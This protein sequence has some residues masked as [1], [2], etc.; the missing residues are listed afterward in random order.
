MAYINHDIDDAVRMGLINIE[1]LTVQ[2]SDL[3]GKTQN[4]KM[5]FLVTNVIS[6]T[7]S[8]KYGKVSMKNRFI[9]A[10]EIMR[11]FLFQNV[12]ESDM[13]CK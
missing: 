11:Y 4:E 1:E 5:S 10:I 2:I 7:L 13:I 12:Y 9:K 3:I 6:T 8:N